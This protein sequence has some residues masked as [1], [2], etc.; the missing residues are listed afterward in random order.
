MVC[1]I[2]VGRHT[3]IRHNSY[4]E[5]IRNIYLPLRHHSVSQPSRRTESDLGLCAHGHHDDMRGLL[6]GREEATAP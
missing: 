1:I 3:G 6:A 2:T 5:S 4:A